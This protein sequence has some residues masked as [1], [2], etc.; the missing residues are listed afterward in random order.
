MKNKGKKGKLT[1]SVISVIVTAVILLAIIISLLITDVFVPV[2]YLSAYCVKA[3]KNKSGEARVNYLN[4]GFGDCT[5]IELPDGKNIL[6]DGGDGS[7]SDVLNILKYL[8]YRGVDRIDYLICTSVKAE[9]CGGLAEIVKY[10]SVGFAYIPYCKNTRITS[11][12]RSFITQ[13]DKKNVP[14]AYACVGESIRGEDYYFAFLSP[15]YYESPLG[16]YAALNETPNTANI[17]NASAVAWLECGG[18]TFAFTSDVRAEG[19]KRIVGE[20]NTAV[21]LNRPYSPA[22]GRAVVLENCNVVTAPAHA[23]EKNTYAPWYDLLKPENTV[24]SVGKSYSGYPSDVALSDICNYCKP[25]YTAYSGDIV[26]TVKQ[27]GYTIN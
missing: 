13:A 8:N 18:V 27:G 20:Y 4:V 23:G 3:H 26:V 10:K 21:A 17:E 15:V 22:G 25:F 1:K 12:Y 24:I 6:I 14:F 2:K 5:L 11:A 19:L 16:E 7:Y 9:H